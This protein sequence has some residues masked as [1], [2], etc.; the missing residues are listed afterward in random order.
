MIEGYGKPGELDRVLD[1]AGKV[2]AKH[3][4]NNRGIVDVK[5]LSTGAIMI[6][7]GLQKQTDDGTFVMVADGQQIDPV[8]IVNTTFAMNSFPY[9]LVKLQ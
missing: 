7:L 8:N 5:F 3:A 2:F 1:F 9:R 6:V 4:A